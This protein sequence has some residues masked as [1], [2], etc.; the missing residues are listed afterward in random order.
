MRRDVWV[1]KCF[2]FQEA[3]EADFEYYRAMSRQERLSIIQELR[4][5]Y[6]KFGKGQTHGARREGLRR[7]LRVIQQT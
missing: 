5:R 1:K 3:E 6:E 2:S 4:E 7:V